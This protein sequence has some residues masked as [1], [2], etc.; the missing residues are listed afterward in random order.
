MASA[1]GPPSASRRSPRVIVAGDVCIDWL[2]IPV[3]SLVPDPKSTEPMNWELRGGRHMYARRGGAWLTADLVEAA[4]ASFAKVVKPEEAPHLENIPP[5]QII[6]SMLTLNRGDRDR[7]KEKVPHWVVAH[8]DGY[9]GPPQSQRPDVKPSERDYRNA[10][11]VLLDDSGNGFRNRRQA[12]PLALS[13]PGAPLVLY[14]VRRPLCKGPLW[15]FLRRSHLKRTIALVTADEL[16]GDGGSIGRGLSWERTAT[17][18][19]QALD[20][21]PRFADLRSC[22]FLV[23]SLGIEAAILVSCEAERITAARMWYLPN[24][25]EGELVRTDRGNMSGFGSAFAAAITS[26]LSKVGRFHP[27]DY[28]RLEGALRKGIPF[29]LIVK[30][31]LLAEAFGPCGL[32]DPA[33]GSRHTTCPPRYPVSQIFTAATGKTIPV[34]E[35]TLPKLPAKSSS[36]ELSRFRSWRILESKREGVFVDLAAEVARQGVEKVFDDVPIGSF[37]R[38]STLDRSEIESYRGISNLMREFLSNPRP[39]RPLCLAVFGAPGSGKSFGVTEV[40]RSVDKKDRIEKLDFNVSQ[41]NDP[42]Y[43]VNALHRVRD[44]AIR[45][46]V[47]L[48]FFDE[49]DSRL[50]T[51]ELGWLKYF[52]APMQDGVF[53]DGLFKHDIGKA[54]FVF[55]GGTATTFETFGVVSARADDSHGKGDLKSLKLPDF[56]SRLRGHVDI[57]GVNPPADT[58]LLRRALILRSNIERK[59]PGLIDAS[60]TVRIDD[61]VLRAFLQ[62][63]SYEHGAR[64]L[65]AIL[66]MS[67]LNDRTHFDP[68]LLPPQHQLSLHV[69]G[70]AFMTLVQHQPLLKPLI[71]KIAI[72]IHELYVREELAKKDEQGNQLYEVG[73][74]DSL[75]HWEDLDELYKKSSREQAASY[76]TLLAAAGCGFKKGREDTNFKFSE[77]ETERLA[78]MEHDRWMEERRLK[79]PDHPDLVPWESLPQEQKDKDIRTIKAIPEILARVGFRAIRLA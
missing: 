61:G 76:P 39:E 66:E 45:G 3:D 53:A 17:D 30:Q 35:V 48:V 31:R 33:D 4:I 73:A 19:I 11:I 60:G 25:T 10:E 34:H 16:R 7:N 55:A 24:L 69:D 70:N 1:T 44:Y 27:L 42:E 51:Q 64:S 8:F 40:A 57:F 63:P 37:G 75:Y 12:W 71:E 54:I 59:Y 9:A 26:A 20:T 18:L 47:P 62:V 46:K 6:H 72:Q 14:K 5:E 65:E 58:N 22:P 28:R 15:K 21:E 43:L 23:I 41:W 74:W 2:S 52:L 67:H 13:S 50:G 38:L 79:Q 49:F 77:K 36:K 32:E 68:S 56:V 29:G 78:C